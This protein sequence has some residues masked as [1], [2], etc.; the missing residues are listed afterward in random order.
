MPSRQNR[1]ARPEYPTGHNKGN[2]R[3]GDEANG[4]PATRTFGAPMG[5]QRPR[6]ATERE[7]L[8]RRPTAEERRKAIE[9]H[10]AGGREE[11]RRRAEQE[12]AGRRTEAPTPTYERIG[13]PESTVDTLRHREHDIEEA[14]E[15]QT[16]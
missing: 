6:Q 10:E 14:V 9:E 7:L 5:V 16:R 2:E 11:T 12:A 4:G 13:K 15:R 3:A 1:E 8:T